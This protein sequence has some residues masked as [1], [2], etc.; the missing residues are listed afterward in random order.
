MDGRAIGTEGSFIKMMGTFPKTLLSL[1]N[2]TDTN[3]LQQ[4]RQKL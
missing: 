3:R 2:G 4:A 1:S